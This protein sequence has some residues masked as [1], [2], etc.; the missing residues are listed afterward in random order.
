MDVIGHDQRLHDQ[1]VSE[2]VSLQQGQRLAC[3]GT[4]ITNNVYIPLESRSVQSERT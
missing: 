4:R 1:A 2:S 3:P